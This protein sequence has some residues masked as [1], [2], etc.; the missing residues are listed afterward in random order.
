MDFDRLQ[1]MIDTLNQSNS[2]NEKQ[3]ALKTFPDQ[4][5]VL[6]YV[7]N[8]YKQFHITS[9][10]LKKRKDLVSHE[11][12]EGDFENLL[13]FLSEEKLTGH[14]ALSAVNGFIEGHKEHEDLI[15]KIIDKNLEIRV[16]VKSINKV[17]PGLIP[18]FSVALANTFDE[19]LAEKIDF[20]KETYYAS[21]KLD[22]VRC[23]ARKEGNDVTFFSR[24]GKEFWTLD[25]LKKDILETFKTFDTIVLDGEI[26]I[27]DEEGNEDFQN[28]MKEIRRK[29]HTI[30][31]PKYMVFDILQT[32]EFDSK[33][34]KS[35]LIERLSIISYVL[36][37]VDAPIP[38]LIEFVEQIRVKDSDHL[39]ELTK[40]AEDRGW[41]GL[42]LRKAA[43]YQGK[44]SNDLL[45]VKKFYDAEYVVEDVEMGPIRYINEEGKEEKV[46]MLSRIYISHKGNKVGVGSGFSMDQRREF[47]EDPSKILGKT[48]TV[49]YF[50]ESQN[51][52][53][54]YSLRFP[55]VKTIHGE[56][57]EV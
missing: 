16:D 46:E 41:E 17:F 42:I 33:K 20:E 8:P 14:K 53:G 34:S 11:W 55:T 23:I 4:K 45:K 44:R 37:E 49:K 25:N 31:R 13:F 3:A 10:N 32:N 28:V 43:P 12:A 24:N 26:C 5:N 39:A 36:H 27:L 52:F 15:Y 56:N 54:E 7:Y 35:T 18:E 1:E 47:Y 51:Q 50:Q 48:I 9:A 30:N 40:M 29:D 2:N 21:H 38:K 6:W 57:R 22:G 19:K